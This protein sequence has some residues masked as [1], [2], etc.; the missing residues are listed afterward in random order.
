MAEQ[1]ERAVLRG[2][3]GA[4]VYRSTP[5]EPVRDDEMSLESL[6]A[7]TRGAKERT[8][9]NDCFSAFESWVSYKV[10][11]P[12]S[13]PLDPVLNPESVFNIKLEKAKQGK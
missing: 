13:L 6:K 1:Q 8:Q 11:I 10:G 4:A 3:I 5:R 12:I 2:R 7:Q 9:R